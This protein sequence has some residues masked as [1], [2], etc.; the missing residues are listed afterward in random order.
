MA[1]TQP[2]HDRRQLQAMAPQY[3]RRHTRGKPADLAVAVLFPD[4]AAWIS[5]QPWPTAEA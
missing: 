2:Q 3:A 5:C 1:E 4:G